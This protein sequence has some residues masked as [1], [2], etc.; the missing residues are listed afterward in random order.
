MYAALWRIL[1][2]PGWAKVLS[3]VGIVAVLSVALMAFVFPFL[4]DTFLVE[5][6]TVGSP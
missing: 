5:G 4:A 1:P 3:C 6:S 2:G